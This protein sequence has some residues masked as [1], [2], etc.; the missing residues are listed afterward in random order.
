MS[1]EG[2]GPIDGPKPT[3]RKVDPEVRPSGGAGS[4]ATPSAGDTVEVS[5]GADIGPYAAELAEI[6]EIRTEKVESLRSAIDEG[7]YDVPA[8]DIAA[9]ILDELI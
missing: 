9:K 4:D 2:I 5:G 8:E 6:P 3:D 1:I 7:S